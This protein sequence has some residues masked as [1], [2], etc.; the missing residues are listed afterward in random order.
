MKKRLPAL[1]E[2]REEGRILILGAGLFAILGL[3]IV[4]GIDVTAVQLA[5]MR[6]LDAADSAALA[7]ADSADKGALYRD[8]IGRGVPLTAGGVQQEATRSL[9]GQ[10][11]PTNVTGWRVAGSSVAGQDTAVVQVEAA[12][13]PPIT[14]GMFSF[15][16]SSITVRV[17]SRAHSQIEP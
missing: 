12:V 4:G 17:E 16:G 9:S 11:V 14:G 15:F 8:G 2:D 7:G 10:Q 13:R 5:K 6:V 1:K 3:L